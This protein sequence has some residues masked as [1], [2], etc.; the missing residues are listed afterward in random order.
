[1]DALQIYMKELH[2]DNSTHAEALQLIEL[3]R[4]GDQAARD[5]VIN[6]YL[7]LVVKV[8]RKYKDNGVLMAD[9]IQEGNLGL[10]KAL[11]KFDPSKGAFPSFATQWIKQG[12]LRN[13]MMNKRAVRLPENVLHDMMAGRWKGEEIREVSI[14]TPND[15]GDSMADDIA[16]HTVNT[17][18]ANEEEMIL[19]RKVENILSFLKGRDADVVKAVFGIGREKPLEVVEAAE[20]FNLST[21]RINQIL[22]NSL[23]QMRVS[24]EALPTS[25]IKEVEIVSA[26]YGSDTSFVDVTDK[27]VDLYLAKE[28]IKSCNRLGG[29]PCIGIVK[30]LVIEYIYDNELLSK[31]FSEGSIVKF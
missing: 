16:D 10:M 26:K 22:R 17:P 8:A 11:E 6:N 1:M 30:S 5:K 12:I 2:N 4:N 15:E 9:L 18:F 13:C 24:H 20:H 19:S 27:V 3:Y 25:N 28:N 29:D 7:L 14:D 21:T 31:T 23:K